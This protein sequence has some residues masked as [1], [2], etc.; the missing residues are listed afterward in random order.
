MYA[1]IQQ[2]ILQ[3]IGSSVLQ[4]GNR[5]KT[6]KEL[7]EEYHVSRTTVVKA[8]TDLAN[9]GIITR[10]AGKGSF[11]NSEALDR[12]SAQNRET[13]SRNILGY[14]APMINDNFSTSILNGILEAL[15]PTKY[16]LMIKVSE[17]H[18]NEIQCVDEFLS[19]GAQGL[20]VFPIDY[21]LYNP[22]ILNLVSSRFPFVLL[23][24]TLPGIQ[25][26][27]VVTDNTAGMN[28]AVD[29]LYALGHKNVCF[30]TT[31]PFQI[32]PIA[33]R[34]SAFNDRLMTYN[35]TMR[36]FLLKDIVQDY[37][38]FEKNEQLRQMLREGEITA[39]L[40]VD[41][42]VAMYVYAAARYLNRRVPED[43]SIVSFD[44]PAPTYGD[45]KFF[46]FVKQDGAELGRNAASILLDQIEGK[47][48]SGSFARTVLSPAREINRSTAQ[49]PH[50]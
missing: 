5:L 29:H 10:T 17:T 19:I 21:E 42:T 30:C 50:R 47:I 22:R 8:L 27:S 7:M 6:E 23:D 24:R 18:A 38:H 13:G 48:P 35:N 39:F 36:P 4:P 33:Q 20:I 9:A 41:S 25:T 43:L 15:K 12:V 40:C 37:A 49:P 16:S 11:V 2:D 32:Q 14:I 34:F 31:S 45:L 3:A 46:T 1:V 28:L 44:D 26:H